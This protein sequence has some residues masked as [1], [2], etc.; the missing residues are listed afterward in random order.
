MPHNIDKRPVDRKAVHDLARAHKW[1]AELNDRL[2]KKGHR[3]EHM[4]GKAIS[5]AQRL[6]L[7]TEN[8]VKVAHQVRKNG[9]NARHNF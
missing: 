3:P 9:N 2:E 4:F 6:R 7:A 8:T 5:E 1:H